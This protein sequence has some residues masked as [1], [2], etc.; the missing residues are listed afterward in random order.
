M[1]DRCQ[2]PMPSACI[3]AA[4]P[5]EPMVLQHCACWILQHPHETRRKNRS[6]PL[7]ELCL[8]SA[9]MTVCKGRR[10][11]PENEQVQQLQHSSG[12]VWLL[13]PGDDAISLAEALEKRR[14]QNSNV[15]G[16]LTLLFMDATWKVRQLEGFIVASEKFVASHLIAVSFA[17]C[18]FAK[19]MDRANMDHQLYP[20][21]TLRVQLT[22]KDL[23]NLTTLRR[24]D[25]R[26]PPSPQHL[27]TAECL[28]WVVSHVENNPAIYDTLMKPLDCMVQQWHSFSDQ[29]KDEEK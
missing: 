2:R 21:N 22:A 12:D 26:T 17:L 6:L 28:A 13:S 5:R 24:F 7:V 23:Q 15:D 14:K 10:L 25:I 8:D 19:E 16:K 4:L 29:Q 11:Y 27:S 9:S 20:P 1:C 3:C 18:K